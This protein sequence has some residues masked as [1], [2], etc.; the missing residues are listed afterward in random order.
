MSNHV[1]GCISTVHPD[2][3]EKPHTDFGNTCACMPE[4]IYYL[5][6]EQLVLTIKFKYKLFHEDKDY[7]G[8]SIKSLII[9]F[10]HN[11]NL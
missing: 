9:V 1:S 4:P 2:L 5:M 3:T 8:G 10:E 6:S 7:S 11:L